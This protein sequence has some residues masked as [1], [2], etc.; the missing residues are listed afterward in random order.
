[1]FPFNNNKTTNH[2]SDSTFLRLLAILLI[3]TSSL[4]YAA[5]NTPDNTS[6]DKLKTPLRTTIKTTLKTIVVTLKP[7]YSLVAHL[8]DGI[9]TPI[10]L[11]SNMQSPHHHNIR[12][13]ERRLLDHADM[14]IWLGPQME[15]YLDKIIQ[16]QNNTVNISLIQA[17]NLSLLNKRSKHSHNKEHQRSVAANKLST[18]KIDQHIWLSITN[19]KAMSRYISESLIAHDSENTKRYKQNLKN[20]LNKIKQ[21]DSGIRKVLKDSRQPF[22]AAHDAFQYFE[23]EYNLNYIAALNSGDD[24]N[25]SLKHLAEIKSLIK[26]RKIQCIVYQQPKPALVDT[27]TKKTKIK[28]AALDPL[29][30]NIT[31]NTNNNHNAWFKT[32]QNIAHNFHQCLRRQ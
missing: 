1:M 16:Q 31:D 25:T 23:K 11:S 22:I 17:E 20:L 6:S 24:T 27:L 19:V 12:P 28:T 13:S 3:L 15:T 9:S 10:L 4:L 7:I 21:T 26:D 5:S 32:M 30:I 18:E 14:I 29:G 2:I 8:T